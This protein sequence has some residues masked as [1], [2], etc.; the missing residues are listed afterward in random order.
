MLGK[1]TNRMPSGEKAMNLKG[2]M[3]SGVNTDIRNP[4]GRVNGKSVSLTP[5]GAGVRTGVAVVDGT[6]VGVRAVARVGFSV[7]V[8]GEGVTPVAVGCAAGVG[9]W[10]A[11]VEIATSGAEVESR[12]AVGSGEPQA[13]RRKTIKTNADNANPI[14]NTIYLYCLIILC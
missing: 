7:A 8:A 14:R 6:G 1:V 9:D 10:A 4:T 13:P 2:P 11:T 12:V 3:D 5:W